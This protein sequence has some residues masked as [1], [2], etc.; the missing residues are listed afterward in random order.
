MLVFHL[1]NHERMR[2]NFTGSLLNVLLFQGLSV[3]RRKCCER[4]VVRESSRAL[5]GQILLDNQ[6]PIA[7]TDKSSQNKVQEMLLKIHGV[8]VKRSKSFLIKNLPREFGI[9]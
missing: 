1:V 2:T 9:F 3:V 8:W 6:P 4:A 5:F 7:A